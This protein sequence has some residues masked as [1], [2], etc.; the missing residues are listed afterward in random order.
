LAEYH[1]DRVALDRFARGEGLAD[2]ERWIVDHLRSGC[3]ICQHHIDALLP[4][5]EGVRS[6]PPAAPVEA[7]AEV[8]GTL[9]DSSFIS[10]PNLLPPVPMVPPLVPPLGQG[11][12]QHGRAARRQ[13]AGDKVDP[14]Q[15]LCGGGDA[16][17]GGSL[18]LRP[19]LFPLLS[20]TAA[21][22]AENEVWDRIFSKLQ[23]RISL[24]ACERKAAPSLVGELLGHPAAERGLM[25]LR[26]RR[27]QTLAVCDLLI[28]TS[29]ETGFRDVAE[30][31]ALADLAILVADQLAA[32]CYSS[33]LVHD[34][35]AR[36]W[37]YLGNARRISSDLVGAE[38]ALSFAESLAEEGSA[39]PLEEARLL[40][41]RAALLNDQGWFE[42]A[43]ELF[44]AVIGIYDEVKDPHRK[45]RALLAMGASVGVAGQPRMAI[46]LISEGLQ[47]ID[48][49]IEPRLVLMAR[50]NLAWFLNDSGLCDQ[51]QQQLES[52][53]HCYESFTD[54]WTQLRLEWLEAR[55]A[56]R[57]KRLDEAERRLCNLRQRFVDRGLGFEASMV[58]LDLAALYL[59]QGRTSAV[60]QL[61]DEMLPIFL[62]QDLHR[63]AAAALVAFQQAAAGHQVTPRLVQEI[64]SYLQ[65]AR[66][67]PSL[68]FERAA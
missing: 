22:E 45:G 37:A 67:N 2:E 14:L 53:R 64:T 40:E 34:T 55:I 28:E 51:A 54:P 42:E 3:A 38:D 46:E 25:V 6:G 47:L 31:V 8:A 26:D 27:F 18:L 43:A 60:Q 16:S 32:S 39:D 41:L 61:T 23:T 35:K 33:A 12:R 24:V 36:A 56:Y 17:D 13:G 9:G 5:L 57:A 66:R 15:E 65:R 1:P 20:S 49:R 7:I 58:M 10:A 21:G 44:D 50:H 4:S 19:R 48:T 59:D 52:F 30:A 62:S 29:F 68:S 63:H 11:G